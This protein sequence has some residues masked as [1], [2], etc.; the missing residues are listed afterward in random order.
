MWVQHTLCSPPHLRGDP[1]PLW[2][3]KLLQPGF[4]SAS[5]THGPRGLGKLLHPPP[6]LN[7]PAY[8]VELA[9]IPTSRGRREPSARCRSGT[10]SIG[11]MAEPRHGQPGSSEGDPEPE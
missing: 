4:R 10:S 1:C 5:V 7:L 9:M 8:N 2:A 11:G 6:S 3:A